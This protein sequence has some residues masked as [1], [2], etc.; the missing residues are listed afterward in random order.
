MIR[1]PPRSTLFP[2]TTLFR[3]VR[4][5]AQ[6]GRNLGRFWGGIGIGYGSATFYCDSCNRRR[7]SGTD[8]T[9]LDGWTLSMGAGWTASPHVRYGLEYRGWLN[10]LKPGDSLP[11]VEMGTFLVSYTPHVRGP[12]LEGGAGV[13]HYSLEHGT[14]DP[15]TPIEEG[16]SSFAAGWGRQFLLGVGWEFRSSALRLTYSHA[17]ERTIHATGDGTVA[18][19]WSP[20]ALLLEYGYRTP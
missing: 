7:T 16:S 18:F 9:R 2:Y 6:I 3:S 13:A 8:H 1:P 20:R 19:G 10:G 12:M 11:T 17:K 14:G 5:N 15:T 4:A